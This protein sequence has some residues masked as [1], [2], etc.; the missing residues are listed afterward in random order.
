MEASGRSSPVRLALWA[1]LASVFSIVYF[2]LTTISIQRHEHC[3]V[4]AALW[5]R[6][7]WML[8]FFTPFA[9]GIAISLLAESRLRRNANSLV[10]SEPELAL[11]RKGLGHPAWKV[12]GVAALGVYI[13]LIALNS[14]RAILFY[15]SLFPLQ[16]LARLYQVVT[17]KPNSVETLSLTT[18]SPIQ[19]EHWGHTR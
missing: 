16:I 9:G 12:L 8:A 15:I 5:G 14:D 4:F 10:Y 1:G 11:L 19:S 7:F 2:L 18:V 13:A 3:S 17:P 6:P